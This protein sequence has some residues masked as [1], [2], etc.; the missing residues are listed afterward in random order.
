MPIW[1]LAAIA[2]RK[3]IAQYIAQDNP[4]AAVELVD[5]LIEQAELLDVNPKIGRHGRMDGTREWVVHPNY[6]IV[7]HLVG[8]PAQVEILRVLHTAQQWP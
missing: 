1:K 8:K 3:K 7:Y 6:V 5:L 2:N 4:V